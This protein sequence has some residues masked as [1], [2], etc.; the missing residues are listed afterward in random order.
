MGI[1]IQQQTICLDG[2]ARCHSYSLLNKI[3]TCAIFLDVFFLTT[4]LLIIFIC[5][6]KSFKVGPQESGHHPLPSDVAQLTIEDCGDVDIMPRALNLVPHLKNLTVTKVQR[7]TLHSQLFE[8][9][10]GKQKICCKIFFSWHPL[11]HS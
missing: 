3:N 2:V 11:F 10:S 8:S 5:F 7:V 4:I 6:L 1:F 9:R